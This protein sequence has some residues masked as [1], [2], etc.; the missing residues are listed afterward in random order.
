MVVLVGHMFEKVEGMIVG[1]VSS[2][3]WL[4]VCG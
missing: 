4:D 1:K 2:R 3:M